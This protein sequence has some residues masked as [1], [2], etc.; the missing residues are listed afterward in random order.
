M[1]TLNTNLP[2]A[3]TH[4]LPRA[5]R[6]LLPLLLAWLVALPAFAAQN[7]LNLLLWSN[8]IDPKVVQSFVEQNNCRV[9]LSVYEDAESM[10]ELIQAAAAEFDVA[11]PP[12]QMV[13]RLIKANL[14]A[15]LHHANLPNL[16]NLDPKFANPPFD[17]GNQYTVG[18]LW[19]TVGIFIRVPAG[20]SFERSWSVIFD[21]KQPLL[22]FSLLDSERELIG[23]ALKFKGWSVNSAQPDQLA[24]AQALLLKTKKRALGLRDS[25]TGRNEV[26]AKNAAAAI[27]FSGDGLRSAK[28]DAATVYFVPKEGAPL[29]M[30]NLAVLKNGKNH[31]LAEKFINHLLDAEV[32]ARN[33]NFLHYATP[34]QAAR[35]FI[36][37]PD[38]ANPGL[39]PL[40]EILSRSEFILQSTNL[41]PRY[42]AVWKELNGK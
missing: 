19:G 39:Y 23:A 18:Y 42:D 16:R 1:R 25:V 11:L 32:G 13:P 9:N 4:K 31:D 14:L 12:A 36:S 3:S 34:N 29:W 38:L 37:P 35:K 21:A 10:L 2:L 17:P 8:Y 40:A 20:K 27:V 41:V 28:E 7:Q 22:P 30:D 24:Q 15:P 33:A 5:L 26:V 6:L